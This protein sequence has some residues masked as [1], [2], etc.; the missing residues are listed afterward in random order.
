MATAGGVV[1]FQSDFTGSLFALDAATGALLAQ[2]AIG[3]A[4]SGPSI[5][6]GRIYVGLGDTFQVGF[7]GPGAIVAVG[8]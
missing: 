1:Y 5:A 8:L 6:D 7:T 3:G 4:I 2:V